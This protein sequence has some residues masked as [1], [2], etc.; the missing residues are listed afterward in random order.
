MKGDMPTPQENGEL[1][2]EELRGIL[3]VL[4]IDVTF[5]GP[6]DKILY[7][8]RNRD[9][10]YGRTA[11]LIGCRVQDC[12]GMSQRAGRAVTQILRSLTQGR[13]TGRVELSPRWSAGCIFS[14]SP[15]ATKRAHSSV[16][17]RLRRT[18]LGLLTV[19]PETRPGMCESAHVPL[20]C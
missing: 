10:I 15:F 5:V 2:V 11:D 17:S 18:S 12:H 8:N 6:D 19:S 3:D 9:K 1:A 7:Y 16:P 20:P 14:T 4:P 13:A